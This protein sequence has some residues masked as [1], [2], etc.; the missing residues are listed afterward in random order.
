MEKQ[1]N[2]NIIN[3]DD[4]MEVI[5]DIY[6]PRGEDKLFFFE[7]KDKIAELTTL[8]P[9]EKFDYRSYVENILE[10][11]EEKKEQEKKNTPVIEID[12]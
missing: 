2:R 7:K 10:A 11:E 9:A 1:R 4:S 12:D 8:K 3:L 5:A 6:D